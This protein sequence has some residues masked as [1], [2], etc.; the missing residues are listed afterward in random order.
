VQQQGP[1]LGTQALTWSAQVL[2]AL[3]Y[4]H[5]QTPPIIH[6]DVKPDN[7]RLTPDG[8]AVLVDFGVAKY[9]VAGQQT[10]TVAR[11]GSP[12]YAPPE[13][14]AGGTDQRTDVYA[15][16]GLLYFALTGEAPL[17]APL[18]AA[19]QR[20]PSPRALNPNVSRS[21]ERLILRA[22]AVDAG[23]RYQSAA[24][25]CRAITEHTKI[26]CPS[27]TGS[28]QRWL[29]IGIGVMLAL[30]LS[31][32]GYVG[33]SM[34][35]DSGGNNGD[36][37]PPAT[38]VTATVTP[39]SAS[40]G[41]EATGTLPPSPTPA[42]THTVEAGQPTSTPRPTFTPTNTPLPDADRDGVPDA[43]DAC[44]DT[45]GLRQ[46]AGCPDTD[47]DGIPYPDDDCPEQSAPD[48]PNGCPPS[49]PPGNNTGGDE[50]D[51]ENIPKPAPG[52]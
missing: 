3:T 20:M 51:N 42:P 6:R 36:P 26:K 12:G 23:R 47:G 30:L 1:L 38:T 32:G 45:P 16:G 31:S 2:D 5:G 21:T 24:A 37:P 43:T 34:W 14:Y 15:V 18:R 41:G 28:Q 10:A 50:N 7:V 9:L 4:L 13:Q 44:R 33:W 52:P 49:P 48:Q 25:M 39:E 8:E 19:G 17:A 29:Q 27:P 35:R 11:A 22:M 46:F 40:V